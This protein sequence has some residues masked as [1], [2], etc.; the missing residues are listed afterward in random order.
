MMLLTDLPS[1]LRT[2]AG[3][4]VRRRISLESTMALRCSTGW[5][6]FCAPFDPPQRCRL[7]IGELSPPTYPYAL[8]LRNCRFSSPHV[9]VQ[10]RVARARPAFLTRMSAGRRADEGA[11]GAFLQP[12]S[13]ACIFHADRLYRAGHND[14][15]DTA[16]VQEEGD[17]DRRAE[18]IEFCS[19]I[20]TP[21]R[22]RFLRRLRDTIDHVATGNFGARVPADRAVRSSVSPL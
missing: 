8:V 5:R 16:G 20:E 19:F 15:D 18:S 2:Y 10:M 7:V 21:D 3:K 14:G 12:Q 17:F 4:N 9:E 22:P 11:F 1:V 6:V 13:T